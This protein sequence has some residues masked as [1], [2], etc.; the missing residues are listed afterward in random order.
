M[1]NHVVITTGSPEGVGSEIVKK[2]LLEIKPN[3]KLRYT[4]LSHN[5]A[6]PIQLKGPWRVKKTD[7][8][9]LARWRASDRD[10]VRLI[11]YSG[12]PANMVKAATQ[13]C[14][15]D[16][17]TAV[18]NAPMRKL[19]SG[20]GHT[21]IIKDMSK[22]KHVTMGFIGKRF[23]VCLATTHIPLEKVPGQLTKS[24]VTVVAKATE[25]LHQLTGPSAD[26]IGVLGLNPHAGDS[27]AISKLDAKLFSVLKQCRLSSPISPMLPADGAFMNG[28]PHRTLLAWYHD[29]GLIPFKLIHGLSMGIQIT[30]GIPFIRTS[31][32]HGT[33]EDLHG[34]GIADHKSMKMAIQWAA[35]LQAQHGNSLLDL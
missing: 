12:S 13:L 21:E 5:S 1:L 31:V 35:K 24:R 18:S 11:S 2:A 14:I 34:K 16:S 25:K 33:A 19:K 32:D 4:V 27:G 10:V 28:A 22:S 26:T 15:D 20:A 8:S 9:E 30:L 17:N 29:Q 7:K 23:N 3:S 6:L